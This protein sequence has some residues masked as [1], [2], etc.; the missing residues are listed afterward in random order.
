[1]LLW[2]LLPE[3]K[4]VSHKHRLICLLIC[5][6]HSACGQY[7]VTVAV[8]L[9]FITCVRHTTIHVTHVFITRVV[10]CVVLRVMMSA[11]LNAHA[12]RSGLRVHNRVTSSSRYSQLERARCRFH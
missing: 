3:K 12:T 7:R 6:L 10:P 11:R 4:L 2:E 1:M 5:I 9:L 8:F